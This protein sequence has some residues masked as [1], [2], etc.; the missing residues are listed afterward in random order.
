MTI[1]WGLSALITSVGESDFQKKLIHS[2]KLL[3][4]ANHCV[5]V[6]Y[7]RGKH[8][9]KTIFTQGD[10]GIDLA[11]QCSTLYDEDYFE[12]DPM[13]QKI[14][15]SER[16]V[17]PV[18]FHPGFD[19]IVDQSYRHELIERCNIIDKLS[20]LYGSSDW[21]YSLNLYRLEGNGCFQVDDLASIHGRG[22]VIFALLKKHIQL[23][24]HVEID[25]SFNWV[26]RR[27]F[28]L[29]KELLTD[30]ERQVC[31]RI[32]LGHTSI[33]IGLNLGISVNT[34]LTH[35]R[36]AYEKLGIGTQSQLFSLLVQGGAIKCSSLEPG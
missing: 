24:D 9:S 12:H 5:F 3:V 20:L 13:F 31:T 26:N 29:Y 25:L 19:D 32:I 1:D 15:I 30:R 2:M 7:P 35:R 22:E 16:I 28:S 8:R 34:I 36:K 10:I 6:K 27:F 18:Y 17:K 21:I 14:I 23:K 11:N 4:G 33:S